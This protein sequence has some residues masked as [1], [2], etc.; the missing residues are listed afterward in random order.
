MLISPFP[1]HYMDAFAARL[2]RAQDGKT[3]RESRGGGRETL[4]GTKDLS[5]PRTGQCFQGWS[6][7]KSLTSCVWPQVSNLNLP[8]FRFFHIGGLTVW[9]G[10]LIPL[11]SRKNTCAQLR[12]RGPMARCRELP[13]SRQWPS[14]PGSNAPQSHLTPT[15]D[16]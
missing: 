10:V 9:R 12:A 14:C 7:T 8:K 1:L 5:D 4:Q 3:T 2:P 16:Q 11:P 6:Q 13:S 15:P